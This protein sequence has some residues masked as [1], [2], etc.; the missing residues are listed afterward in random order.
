[1]P[2]VDA[3]LLL[4]EHHLELFR[5]SEKDAEERLT[6]L[7]ASVGVTRRLH[8]PLGELVDRVRRLSQGEFPAE[9]PPTNRE[10]SKATEGE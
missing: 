9:E 2:N 3:V 7:A 4:M 10:G 5:K 8:E 1:M 6:T